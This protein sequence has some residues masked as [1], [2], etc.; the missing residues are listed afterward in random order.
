ML[1]YTLQYVKNYSGLNKWAHAIL[2]AGHEASMTADSTL[3]EDLESFLQKFL[4]TEDEIV[5]FLMGDH[6]MRYGK[7]GKY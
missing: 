6:G 1:N 7:Y 2:M 5:I 3:D 4:R